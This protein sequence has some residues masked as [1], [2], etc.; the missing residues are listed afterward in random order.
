MNVTMGVIVWPFFCTEFF[1]F[2]YREG[3]IHEK[4][5]SKNLQENSLVKLYFTRNSERFAPFFLG[6]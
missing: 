6:F 2:G 5:I 4:L 3:E 1:S